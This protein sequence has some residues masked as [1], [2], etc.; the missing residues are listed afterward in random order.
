MQCRN[1]GLRQRTVSALRKLAQ[2]NRSD[3]YANESQ[4]LNPQRIEHATNLPSLSLIEH[5]HEPRIAF[6][7]TENRGALGAHHAISIHAYAPHE[8]FCERTVGEGRN[9]HM[10]CFRHV[11]LWIRDS[12]GPLRIVCQ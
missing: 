3:S 9:L 1:F 5:D 10:I 12:R 7:L 11:T 6:A 8:L 4:H 2:F